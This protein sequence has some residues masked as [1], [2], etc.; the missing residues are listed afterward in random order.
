MPELTTILCNRIVNRL[1]R[2]GFD[3]VTEADVRAVFEMGEH[4]NS[5]LGSAIINELEELGLL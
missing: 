3:D 4:E 2:D 1:K 5:A